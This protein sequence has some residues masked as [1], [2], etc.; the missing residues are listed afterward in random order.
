MIG[1]IASFN[2]KPIVHTHVVLG[3]RDGT[4]VGGH[5]WELHVNPSLDVFVTADT[6]PLQKKPD[7][8]P[9]MKFIDPT[10]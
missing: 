7:E 8:A 4:T 2:G 10:Q 1:D 3:H 5:M 6:I 9:G